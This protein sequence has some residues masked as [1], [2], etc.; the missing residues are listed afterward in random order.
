MKKTLSIVASS[1]MGL[2]IG[3]ALGSA[4]GGDRVQNTAPARDEPAVQRAPAWADC[5]KLQAAQKDISHLEDMIELR[6]T[7]LD[8]IDK[9]L[10]EVVGSP[11]SWPE[12]LPSA[13]DEAGILASLQQML[14][15]QGLPSSAIAGIDCGEYPCIASLHVGDGIEAVQATKTLVGTMKDNAYPWAEVQQTAIATVDG[16][17]Q[18]W[19]FVAL[20]ASDLSQDI[21]ASTRLKYLLSEAHDGAT[22]AD[23][24][25]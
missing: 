3:F 22:E 18:I 1:L 11:L 9:S 23:E 4:G 24:G 6:K 7:V 2:S 5:P 19:A 16:D 14:E 21:N 17:L 8:H 20:P 15:S 12:K 10:A 25:P 13:F